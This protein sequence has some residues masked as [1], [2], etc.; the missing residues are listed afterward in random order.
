MRELHKYHIFAR[1]DRFNARLMLR[2]LV[3]IARLAGHTGLFVAVD[4]LEVLRSRGP[5]GRPRYTRGARDEFYES[6]RQL[7]DDFDGL[8]HTLFCFAFRTELVHD[9]FLGLESY[10][11]LWLC[12][13]SETAG[14]RVNRFGD[15]LD[16]DHI[17]TAYLAE[18]HYAELRSRLGGLLEASGLAA[19][20]QNDV[21]TPTDRSWRDVVVGTVRSY[22][23]GEDDGA[24]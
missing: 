2:A 3:E 17:N 10:E 8:E 16:L 4:G 21:E 7:I 24:V 6:L 15:L 20:P 1:I 9:R 5:N 22:A 13:I 18:Q 23:G 11:A 12:I 14:T 19:A